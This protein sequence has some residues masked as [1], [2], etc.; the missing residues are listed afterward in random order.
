MRDLCFIQLCTHTSARSTRPSFSC[1]PRLL[2]SQQVLHPERHRL[3]VIDLLAL[4]ARAIGE[5]ARATAERPSFFNAVHDLWLVVSLIFSHAIILLERWFP[6]AVCGMTRLR[7]LTIS[8]QE[9]K[10]FIFATLPTGLRRLSL[11]E[12]LCI[13]TRSCCAPRV[14]AAPACPADEVTSRVQRSD[15]TR[16]DVYHPPARWLPSAEAERGARHDRG[17]GCRVE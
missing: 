12:E 4:S 3:A 9:T 1:G 16:L 2:R 6:D 15:G 13:E 17:T 11:L 10:E 8:T 7:L 14:C 5:G